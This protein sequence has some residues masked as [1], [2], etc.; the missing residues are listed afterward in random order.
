MIAP[1]VAAVRTDHV[2]VARLIG[3]RM[4]YWFPVYG[5]FLAIGITSR[6]VWSTAPTDRKEDGHGAKV[7]AP[8]PDSGFRMMDLTPAVLKD[9]S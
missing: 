8:V 7:S 4:L 9:R 6:W 5:V 3:S 2:D 1:W